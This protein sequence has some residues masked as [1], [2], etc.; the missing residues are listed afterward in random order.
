MFR[1]PIWPGTTV[2][3]RIKK[4][5]PR[6]DGEMV[7][8][9]VEEGEDTPEGAPTVEELGMDTNA[10]RETQAPENDV[11]GEAT[12]DKFTVTTARI[13]TWILAKRVAIVGGLVLV[14]VALLVANAVMK[15]NQKKIEA[16]ASTFFEGRVAQREARETRPP[17]MLLGQDADDTKALT[18]EQRKAKLEKARDPFEKVRT[19]NAGQPLARTATLNL[20]STQLELG[21]HGEA[22]KLYDALLAET[23]PALDPLTRALALQ[24]KAVAHEV[25]GQT[26]ESIAAWK[27]V[28]QANPKVYGLPAALNISRLQEAAGQAAEAKATLEKA[29]TE[30]AKALEAPGSAPYKRDLEA[31]LARLSQ[32]T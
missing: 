26:P 5:I 6:A 32:G 17:M 7:E 3:K 15:S 30:Q 29:Q 18:P 24:A 16:A 10:R 27:L 19:E 12:E 1:G 25:G 13:V 23:A 21:N 28:E 4:R 9:E 14:V 20:A 31:R 11:L 2:V 8:V 22:L